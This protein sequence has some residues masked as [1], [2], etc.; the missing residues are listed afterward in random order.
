MFK[1]LRQR[2]AKVKSKIKN[3]FFKS[4]NVIQFLL[5]FVYR[6][7][8]YVKNVQQ[9][10]VGQGLIQE[11]PPRIGKLPPPPPQLDR[12]LGEKVNHLHL[13]DAKPRA[14]PSFVTAKPFVK[15]DA[16]PTAEQI[17]RMST[18]PH[19][20]ESFEDLPP[21]P[22]DMLMDPVLPPLQTP[23]P[24]PPE[25]PEQ[26]SQKRPQDPVREFFDFLDEQEGKKLPGKLKSPFLHPA[27]VGATSGSCNTTACRPF[28]SSSPGTSP[29][30]NQRHLKVVAPSSGG[31]TGSRGSSPRLGESTGMKLPNNNNNNNNSSGT[32][33][34]LTTDFDYFPE[35]PK[36]QNNNSN[37]V[38]PAPIN[39]NNNNN[40]SPSTQRRPSTQQHQPCGQDN[41][42]KY[43][44]GQIPQQQQQQQEMLLQD[45]EGHQQVGS[46]C[47]RKCSQPIEA[48]TVAIFAERAGSDKCWH[49]QCFVCSICHVSV[50]GC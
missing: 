45:P 46:W 49:P 37:R 25:V 22:P 3:Y 42:G 7:E 40:P 27:P 43:V 30:L 6:M 39:N 8:E 2:K 24:P 21:P 20:G 19:A 16:H 44:T 17:K 29:N 15:A 35:E 31:G 32:R 4:K 33:R 23:P 47:C 1:S 41:G 9:F 36:S 13:K 26:S 5:E 34:L 50:V 48:G 18:K 12:I 14:V 10:V 11:C 28:G 38:V